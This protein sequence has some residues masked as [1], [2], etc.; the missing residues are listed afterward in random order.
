LNLPRKQRR[1][2]H[3]DRRKAETAQVLWSSSPFSLKSF[4]LARNIG[5]CSSGAFES[6][7]ERGLVLQR[8][9]DIGKR[10]ILVPV[11]QNLKFAVAT[12]FRSVRFG[13]R[14]RS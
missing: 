13:K 12:E 10:R 14:S 9:P 7:R 3:N 4:L 11:N 8:T 2:Y 1:Q 6:A 5:P